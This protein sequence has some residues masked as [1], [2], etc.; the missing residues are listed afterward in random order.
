MTMR[1]LPWLLS[2]LAVGDLAGQTSAESRDVAGGSAAA[3]TVSAP[4]RTPPRPKSELKIAYPL[5]MSEGRLEGEA[6]VA[7]EID[8]AGKVRNVRVLRANHYDFGWAATEGIKRWSFE[9]A[10]ENGR[11][12]VTSAEQ[13]VV[14]GTDRSI[15]AHQLT[16]EV[17]QAVEAMLHVD[18]QPEP[19]QPLHIVYPYDLLVAGKAG[20]AKVRYR[21][22]VNGRV[23]GNDV[24]EASHPE[25]GLA[26][27]AAIEAAEFKPA[28]DAGQPKAV[29]SKTE[30]AFEPKAGEAG[31]AAAELAML[32]R[33]RKQPQ[34]IV[35]PKNLDAPLRAVTQP[36]PVFPFAATADVKTGE[37][38]IEFIVDEEGT[39]RLP[40]IHQASGPAFGYAAVQAAAAWRFEPPS[41]GGKPAAVRARIP[42]KFKRA[43]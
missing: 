26:L 21:V 10:T 29:L 16:F 4:V 2:I 32:E 25:F 39:V 1:A 36:A 9:P 7:F 28:L 43:D 37:A 27:T 34:T 24:M 18:V 13:I 12:V 35:S 42:F 3:S 8:E 19:K 31:P 17:T 38:L 5:A 40:R 22:D 33:E 20:R 41:A 11:P 30:R 14:F 6:R 23:D 15:R